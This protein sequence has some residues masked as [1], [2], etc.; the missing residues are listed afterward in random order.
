MTLGLPALA[1]HHNMILVTRN[2]KD[3]AN[4]PIQIINPFT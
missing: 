1:K 2:E 4:L 3:F